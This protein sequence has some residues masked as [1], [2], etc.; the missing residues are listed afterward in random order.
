M[1]EMIFHSGISN[2][3]FESNKEDSQMPLKK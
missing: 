3:K 2:M 1:D